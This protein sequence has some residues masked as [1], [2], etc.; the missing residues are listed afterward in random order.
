MEYKGQEKVKVLT[1]EFKGLCGYVRHVSPL[2]WLT[3]VV[4]GSHPKVTLQ[5]KDVE[6]IHPN[7]FLVG[8]ESYMNSLNVNGDQEKVKQISSCEKLNVL[9]D[10]FSLGIKN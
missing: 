6:F 9:D 8:I 7:Y 3:I 5:E 2:G 4:N 10:K 1:G